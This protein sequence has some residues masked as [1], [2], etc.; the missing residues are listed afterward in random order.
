MLLSGTGLE[1]AGEPSPAGSISLGFCEAGAKNGFA[2]S[3]EALT[4]EGFCDPA[5]MLTA[6]GFVVKACE[7]AG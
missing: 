2:E 1:S 5:R 6:S 3:V 4:D 7:H